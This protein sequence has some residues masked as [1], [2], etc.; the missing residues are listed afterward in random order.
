MPELIV[1]GH[2]IT[3]DEFSWIRASRKGGR[4]KAQSVE[5]LL[6]LGILEELRKMNAKQKR[7]K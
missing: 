5:A 1:R 3:V 6:M 2:F 4:I 7:R